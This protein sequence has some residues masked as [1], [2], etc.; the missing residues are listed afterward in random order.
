MSHN[1]HFNFYEG[2]LIEIISKVGWINVSCIFRVF[3][4]VHLLSFAFAFGRLFVQS[5][6]MWSLTYRRPMSLST[7]SK[8]RTLKFLGDICFDFFSLW[9]LVWTIP[10]KQVHV[11]WV[12]LSITSAIVSVAMS[13]KCFIFAHQIFNIQCIQFLKCLSSGVSRHVIFDEEL[14]FLLCY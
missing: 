6:K 5:T 13:P 9:N 3:R 4:E 14:V 10:L 12:V 2:G 7:T 1:R 8:T 11:L